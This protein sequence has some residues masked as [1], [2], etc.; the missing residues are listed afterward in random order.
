MPFC[1]QAK[2]FAKLEVRRKRFSAGSSHK[3]ALS[4]ASFEGNERPREREMEIKD[5]H[6]WQRTK[7]FTSL[8]SRELCGKFLFDKLSTKVWI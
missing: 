6:L 5:R 1:F 7:E 4:E 8:I 2:L 3:I